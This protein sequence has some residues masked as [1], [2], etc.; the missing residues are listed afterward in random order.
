[1][2]GLRLTEYREEKTLQIRRYK[3][4]RRSLEFCTQ[5]ELQELADGVPH[6]ALLF[7]VRV[8]VEFRLRD[9]K[10]RFEK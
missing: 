10:S 4:C 1:M 7:E 3:R 6:Q 8:W 9:I 5:Q 2:N